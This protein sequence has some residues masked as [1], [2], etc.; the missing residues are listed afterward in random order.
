MKKSSETKIACIRCNHYDFDKETITST[1]KKM[2]D[3]KLELF[4][5]R[6]KPDWCPLITP[7]ESNNM[8]YKKKV[9]IVDAI[10]WKGTEKSMREIMEFTKSYDVTWQPNANILSIYPKS[11]HPM[12]LHKDDWITKSEYGSLETYESQMFPIYWTKLD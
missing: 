2:P 1:C 8:K 10:Q 4:A 7:E 5:E 11:N 3:K 12:L 6:L 9:E